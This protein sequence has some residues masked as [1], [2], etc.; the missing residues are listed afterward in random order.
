MSSNE[1]EKVNFRKL[2]LLKC[3]KEFEKDKG[4]DIR[5][6]EQRKKIEEATTVSVHLVRFSPSVRSLPE[7]YAF[8]CVAVADEEQKRWCRACKYYS[9]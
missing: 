9:R 6:A 4:E 1:A 3:Q 5:K 7:V 2:L 8:F